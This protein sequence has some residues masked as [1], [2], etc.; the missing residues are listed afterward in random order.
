MA[1]RSPLNASPTTV[2][3]P[4]QRQRPAESC[5]LPPT[6]R[7]R[8]EISGGSRRRPR[9]TAAAVSHLTIRFVRTETA[10][11]QAKCRVDLLLHRQLTER[12]TG[13]RDTGGAGVRVRHVPGLGCPARRE[14]LG[15]TTRWMAS[16]HP[17][18]G[19]HVLDRLHRGRGGHRCRGVEDGGPLLGRGPARARAG[20]LLN[21]VVERSKGAHA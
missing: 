14:D 6:L 19:S 7:S 8:S 15:S 1:T 10:S 3:G 13:R 2:T 18:G 5:R 12:C 21:T 9:E 16:R 4:R 11:G 20:C 17:G